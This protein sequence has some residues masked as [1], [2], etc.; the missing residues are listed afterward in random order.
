MAPAG[1]FQGIGRLL[2]LCRRDGQHQVSYTSLRPKVW[3]GVAAVWLRRGCLHR[4]VAQSTCD[5]V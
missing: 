2:R 3:G 5:W 4:D 1:G